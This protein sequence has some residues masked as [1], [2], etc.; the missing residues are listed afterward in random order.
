[1]N[2]NIRDFS[3]QQYKQYAE[4]NSFAWHIDAMNDE[5]HAVLLACDDVFYFH[6]HHAYVIPHSHYIKMNQ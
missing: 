2:E 3:K 1:M 5:R 4:H 6:C